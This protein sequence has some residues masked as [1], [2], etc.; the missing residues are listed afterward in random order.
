MELN[1]EF[2]FCDY[3]VL[4][5]PRYWSKIRVLPYWVDVKL[6]LRLSKHNQDSFFNEGLF[7]E[8]SNMFK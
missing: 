5:C 3:K 7:F 6:E 4:K 2:E 8:K 1:I